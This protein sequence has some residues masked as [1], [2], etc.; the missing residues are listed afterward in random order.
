MILPNFQI[1]ENILPKSPA[2]LL[3]DESLRELYGSR[4]QLMR[5]LLK[6]ENAAMNTQ[7][8]R[9]IHEYFDLCRIQVH[10]L[11][12]VFELVDDNPEGKLCTITESSCRKAREVIAR[13]NAGEGND[14]DLKSCLSEFFAQDITSI[15]FLIKLSLSMDRMDV[16]R[17]FTGLNQKTR[18][19]FEVGFQAGPGVADV[20][21]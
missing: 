20:A 15:A 16:A 2:K 21:A 7:L 12:H 17:I 18:A 6:M 11:E 13:M 1:S 3:F 14:K 10:S 9:R 5:T 4:N 19:T 8:R